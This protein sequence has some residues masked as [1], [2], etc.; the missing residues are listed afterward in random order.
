MQREVMKREFVR[1]TLISIMARFLPM[2]F[3][4]PAENPR[5]AYGCIFLV[6]PLSF[7]ETAAAFSSLSSSSGSRADDWATEQQEN[8]NAYAPCH[9]TKTKPKNLCGLKASGSSQY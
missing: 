3:R 7:G 8:E 1:E 9:K 5:N 6:L 2:H 4:G